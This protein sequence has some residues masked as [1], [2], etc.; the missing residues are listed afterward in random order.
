MPPVP[1]WSSQLSDRITSLLLPNAT[2]SN[3]KKRQTNESISWSSRFPK[4][5]C[6]TNNPGQLGAKENRCRWKKM[7]NRQ[8]DVVEEWRTLAHD[9]IRQFKSVTQWGLHYQS[10]TISMDLHFTNQISSV[11]VVR[12]GRTST[13]DMSDLCSHICIKSP[14]RYTSM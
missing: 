7:N 13:V 6:E 11:L 4:T 1:G 2:I 10:L 3:S 14:T 5:K 12:Q 9:P 8:E